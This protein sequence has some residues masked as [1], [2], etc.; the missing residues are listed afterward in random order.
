MLTLAV[1]MIVC[2][3]IAVSVSISASNRNTRESLARERAAQ[4]EADR[5]AAE[6]AEVARQK[7]C[8]VVRRVGQA[9][10]SEPPVTPAGRNVAEAWASL[11]P[12]FQC[13]E[14]K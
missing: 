3:I 11:A 14:G 6:V 1:G 12:I 8:L 13:T 4:A 7:I 9:Y 5:K 2:M 10:E